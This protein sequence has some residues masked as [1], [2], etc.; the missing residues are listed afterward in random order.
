MTSLCMYIVYTILADLFTYL[1]FSTQSSGQNIWS[2]PHSRGIFSYLLSLLAQRSPSKMTCS[3]T[4]SDF[5]NKSLPNCYLSL[6]CNW[7]YSGK[8]RL[9]S[10]SSLPCGN[11]PHGFASLKQFSH[12]TIQGQYDSL[13]DILANSIVA[14]IAVMV[15]LGIRM[16]C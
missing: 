1:N 16:W 6:I 7:I 14:K 5:G 11:L 12:K 10:K 2:N 9:L 4:K 15:P 8:S 3:N 13:Y